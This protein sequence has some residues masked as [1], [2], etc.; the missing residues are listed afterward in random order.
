M[1]APFDSPPPAPSPTPDSPPEERDDL[2]YPV[3]T[4]EV[5][6]EDGLVAAPPEKKFN[7]W[8]VARE[9]L[10]TL[11]LTALIFFAVNALTAR[12]KIDGT[13]MNNTFQDGQYILV[14]RMNYVVF[15]PQRGDVVVFVPPNSPENSFWERIL[16]LPGETD[17]IKRV[18]GVPGD[19][20][21]IDQG[22]VYVNGVL[23]Y[24]PYI[25]EPMF[26]N[27]P[28]SWVLGTDQY[29]V[30]GDNRNASQD[31]RLPHI[32]PISKTRMV[33]QVLAIYFPLESLVWV[34]HFRHPELR[35]I[36]P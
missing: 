13:S 31:S 33:G 11:L 28:Q 30:M 1:T 2:Y 19:E 4:S 12:F 10:E 9:I 20:I 29:F 3:E 18:I 22:R 15:N 21:A 14:S 17:F 7:L 23:L 24:E 5:A 32:G 27:S 34:E 25:R 26:S 8:T 36:A 6:L 16:G 35:G